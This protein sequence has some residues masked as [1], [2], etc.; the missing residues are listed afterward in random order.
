MPARVPCLLTLNEEHRLQSYLQLLSSSSFFD[1]FRD[2]FK[3]EPNKILP[4][5][6][7]SPIS[8]DG[9]LGWEILD[10]ITMHNSDVV[11]A[12]YHGL[13]AHLIIDVKTGSEFGKSVL[14]TGACGARLSLPR[15]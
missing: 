15:S 4:Q 6:G 1:L 12:N 3:K 10:D 9:I 14:R 2:G 13:G 5:S 7:A 11:V 8:F